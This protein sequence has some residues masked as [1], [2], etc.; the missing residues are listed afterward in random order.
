LP[1]DVATIAGNKL[2]DLTVEKLAA[3]PHMAAENLRLWARSS[4]SPTEPVS[5]ETY[6]PK[7]QAPGKFGL[8]LVTGHSG[9]AMPASAP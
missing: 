2:E 9:E 4:G 3:Y 8:A 1:P 5:V 6:T 7:K